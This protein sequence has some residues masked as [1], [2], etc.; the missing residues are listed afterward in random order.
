MR[1]KGAASR[2]VCTDRKSRSVADATCFAT[3]H[4]EI[5]HVVSLVTTIM[6]EGGVA[7]NGARP[8]HVRAALTNNHGPA[9]ELEVSP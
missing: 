8:R 2:N 1:C 9:T 3:D 4:H 7:R 6:E 5:L